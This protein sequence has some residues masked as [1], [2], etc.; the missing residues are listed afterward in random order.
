MLSQKAIEEFKQI[1]K[2]EQGIE[3][4]DERAREAAERLLSLFRVIYRPLPEE[5]PEPPKKIFK[6]YHKQVE[7][8]RA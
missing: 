7:K 1:M 8:E 6:K 4:S 2:E 5:R 3:L